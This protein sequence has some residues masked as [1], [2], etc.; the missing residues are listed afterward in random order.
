MKIVHVNNKNRPSVKSY[1]TVI[2]RGYGDEPVRLQ[3]VGYDGK[4]VEVV[5]DD[6]NQSV[7]FPVQ[8]IYADRKHTYESLKAAY[9]AGDSARLSAL[10]KSAD[11]FSG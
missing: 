2:V 9:E 4:T 8:W 7:N 5:G 11:R 1:V 10:W 3:A 6:P